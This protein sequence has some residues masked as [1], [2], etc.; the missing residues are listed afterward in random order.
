MAT[1]REENGEFCITASP[2]DQDC[3]HT[4]L[5]AEGAGCQQLAFQ[6][7]HVLALWGLTTLTNS[8]CEKRDELPYNGLAAYADSS[9]SSHLK[10][11]Q[12][13]V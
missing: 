4:D 1:A 2:C 5:V 8:M 6:R 3:W 13:L 10:C 7:V 11:T 12:T 9:S